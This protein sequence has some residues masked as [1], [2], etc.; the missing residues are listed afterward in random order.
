[1]ALIMR[2]ARI[3]A[4]V[5]LAATALGVI[6]V[7]AVYLYLAPQLPEVDS[8]RDVD[9]QI[10]LRV[11]SAENELIAEFG[12]QRRTPLA[13]DE[14]PELLIQAF[15]AAEDDRFFEHPGVDYQGLLRAAINLVMTRQREQGGSTITMQVARNFFLTRE[16]TYRRK[17][18]EIF[19]A[20]RIERALSKE[21]IL[22]LYL[23][24]IFMGNRAYGVASAGQTYF[25]KPVDKLELHEVAV[26]A[27]LP[28][29]PSALNPVAS[30][31][32]ALQRRNYVLGRMRR[33]DYISEDEYRQ[34]LEQPVKSRLHRRVTELEAPHAAEMVRQQMVERFGEEATYT[35]GYTVYT[36]LEATAQTAALAGLR[37]AVL[38]YD[39]RRGYRGTSGRAERLPERPRE[40]GVEEDVGEAGEDVERL[41][42]WQ[43]SME[44]HFEDMRVIG[45]MLWPAAVMQVGLPADEEETGDN[46]EDGGTDGERRVEVY[47]RDHGV[48]VIDW[49]GVRWAREYISEHE[50]GPELQGPEEV[51]AR[52][53]LVYVTRDAGQWLLAQLPQ[54]DGALVALDPRDGGITALAGGFDYS[55]SEFNRA[56]SALR[57]VGSAFK[58]FLY[59]AALDQGYTAASIVQDA[60]VVFEDEA[61][62][63][64]WRP[65]NYSGRFFGPTRL[66]EGLAHSRNL[67]S[68]RLLRSLGVNYAV[69]YVTRFGFGAGRLPRDLSLSLGTMTVSPLELARAY[70][71]F[72]NGGFLVDPWLVQRIEDAD[73]NVI[74]EHAPAIA[75]EDCPLPVP[76]P[77]EADAADPADLDTDA[78]A[79]A[80]DGATA[81]DGA[82]DNEED[83]GIRDVPD[84]PLALQPRAPRVLEPETA[85]VMHSML[86]E[87]IRSG[88]GQRATQL[89]RDDIAGKTGT[90][91]DFH[92]AWF[93]GYGDHLVATAWLGFDQ[94]RSLGP[95]EAGSVAAG[96][97][98]IDFMRAALH[99]KPELVR[100][101]PPGM[102]SVRISPETGLRASADDP[103]AIFE[104]FPADQ[105]PPPPDDGEFRRSPGESGDERQPGSF[106]ELF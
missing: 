44:A 72:A 77:L 76:Q 9:Y 46:T 99:G 81:G 19:L 34:A 27:G 86:R 93:S 88:T 57:Q 35:R 12:T 26:L 23:N 90:T 106:E 73:G 80:N 74:Y 103:D 69:D 6:T 91:N 28:K 41:T 79:L 40:A 29:G 3:G 36:S 20:L 38:A 8:L 50:R 53:D 63:S 97:M 42:A 66:R 22:E 64:T 2:I 15:L 70:A 33:L 102:V 78:A 94:A 84:D 56:S 1:M 95:G 92:D 82:A 100:E 85:Y 65:E 14:F 16:R 101:R 49:D 25:G 47:I 5:F 54:V 55:R 10:P 68:I 18:R 89:D 60:P 17:I 67:V 32:R 37:R 104:I 21:Q 59:S 58:P 71:V 45:D 31:E 39:R 87:V 4:V 13:Y 7:V 83:Y 24:K 11:M 98:W 96:P 62:E 61:L 75:C 52:G 105:V 48:A 51:L 30:P 43:A